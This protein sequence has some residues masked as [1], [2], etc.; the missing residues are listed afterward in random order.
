ME[1]FKA[2]IVTFRV[3]HARNA[4]NSN[5]N[6][7]YPNSIP[8]QRYVCVDSHSSSCLTYETSCLE[9]TDWEQKCARQS[10]TMAHP[11]LIVQ[12]PHLLRVYRLRTK[13]CKTEHKNGPSTTPCGSLVPSSLLSWKTHCRQKKK[14]KQQTNKKQFYTVSVASHTTLNQ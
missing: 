8:S 1:S 14:R 2:A 4:P 6:P 9:S 10:I 7:L 3:S 5:S 13:L 12:L 11:Q